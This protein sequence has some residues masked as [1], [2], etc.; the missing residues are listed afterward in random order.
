MIIGMRRASLAVNLSLA[1]L[2]HT[3]AP[4]TVEAQLKRKLMITAFCAGGGYGGLKLG[5]KL[6]EI[7][8]KKLK[9]SPAEAAKHRLAFQ[10][11]TALAVCAGGALLANT[12]YGKLSE[13]DREAL[14]R[15]VD[16]A[17]A[18]AR[19]ATHNF[20][21]P[22]SQYPAT[23][24]TREIVQEGKKSCRHTVQTLNNNNDERAITKWCRESEDKP[25]QAEI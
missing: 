17:V 16:A 2:I 25:Y 12:V 21:L 6:A 5:E 9:L 22:D 14:R 4:L 11:G 1:L 3:A 15:N 13:R 10:V 8:A 19:P 23:I 20:V 7:E 24:E 18:D